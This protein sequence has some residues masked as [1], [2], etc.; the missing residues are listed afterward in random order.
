[1]MRLI[2]KYPLC[3]AFMLSLVLA[4]SVSLALYLHE[5]WRRTTFALIETIVDED[6]E[7][8]KKVKVER[9]EPNREQVRKMARHQELKQREKLKENAKKLRK[10]VLD[11][12]E[13]V[14]ARKES[15]ASPD[16]WDELAARAS[17]LMAQAE[18]QRYRQSKSS[19]LTHQPGVAKNLIDLRNTTD[20][21][22][23]QMRVLAL[24]AETSNE[25]AWAALEQAREMLEAITSAQ[26]LIETA[27]QIAVAMPVD[28]KQEKNV[29]FMQE[30]VEGLNQL[31]EEG[32]AYLVD[33][34]QLLMPDL[35]LQDLSEATQMDD[36][37][38][39]ESEDLLNLDSDPIALAELDAKAQDFLPSEA[40]I[41]AMTAAE[42]YESIQTMTG[43]LDDAFAENKAIELAEFKQI[44]LEEAQD[45]VYAPTTDPGPD[46]AG[47]LHQNQPDT[48]AAFQTFNEAL[49]QAVLSSDRIAR[50]AENRL[51]SANGGESSNANATQTA[52]QLK[53]ALRQAATLKAKM[54]MA[55]S[56]MGRSEGNLQDLRSLMQE[57]YANSTASGGSDD[58]GKAGLSSAYDSSSFLLSDR[59]QNNPSGIR[60]NSRKTI[61]QALPGRRFDMDSARKGWIFIDTWYIIGPWAL[62]PG[63]DF[64]QPFPPETMVDL[65]ASYE[66]KLHPV[67]KQPM[68]LKW[69][70]IQSGS[71]RIKPPDELSSTVYF[72]YTEVFCASTM[73]VVVAVASDDRAKLW[74][75]DLVVFQDVGLSGWQLDEGFRRVLLKPGY[76]Q[77]L[78]RLENGPIVANFSVLMCPSDSVLGK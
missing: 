26:N 72:A 47:V 53:Q 65:D 45:Q 4:A 55:G 10:T 23:K 43:Q 62:P 73:D 1:M 15:L 60:L 36:L 52:D 7:L 59:R 2:Q 29:R 58:T 37:A 33:F 21:H 75:N 28:R 13:V 30:R 54:S 44:P 64:E 32:A 70:F 5:D 18:E 71:L 8:V 9:S 51:N 31:A 69:R 76:N 41:E 25:N 12:E 74:I 34:E 57:S 20:A 42:L 38:E 39:M 24:Q 40:D 66:G 3:T 77:L 17:R 49:K 48:N 68:Q 22:A 63:R 50:Q 78:L 61:A 67:T 35:S 19:F 16:I 46:L 11:L 14:E 6:G 27:Y 56:N